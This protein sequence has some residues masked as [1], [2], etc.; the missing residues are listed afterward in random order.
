[1]E[2]TP[3]VIQIPASKFAIVRYKDQTYNNHVSPTF[4]I[5][6]AKY[7]VPENSDS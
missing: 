3:Q 7:P 2:L 1:M 4:Y 6:D 5:A